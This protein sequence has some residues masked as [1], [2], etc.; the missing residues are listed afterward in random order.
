M[1][2]G[3]RSN[4]APRLGSL[5]PRRR[6]PA[7]YRFG[8]ISV[9]GRGDRQA[10]MRSRN[11]VDANLPC[12][13]SAAIPHAVASALLSARSGP[14]TAARRKSALSPTHF[15]PLAATAFGSKHEAK[16]SRL[17][18]ASK[19][20]PLP[21]SG[22]TSRRRC[23]AATGVNQQRPMARAGSARS[24]SR[25]SCSDPM[26]W[27]ALR[28]LSPATRGCTH[29]RWSRARPRRGRPALGPPGLPAGLRRRPGRVRWAQPLRARRQAGRIRPCWI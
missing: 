23:A 4:D 2:N 3:G 9:V 29:E 11:T 8:N 10:S 16:S 17:R 22:H 15:G 21:L 19:T 25:E 12:V 26:T 27:H 13:G 5:R 28:G 1:W 7:C 20:A 14:E 24:Q 6:L 18:S